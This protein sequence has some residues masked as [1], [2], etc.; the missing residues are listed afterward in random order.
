M[1]IAFLSTFYPYR[2]GIAQFSGALLRA[3][4]HE[5]HEVKAFNFT[6]QYPEF[7]FP[8]KTQLVNDKDT[9][10]PI[11]SY[12]VLDSI[13]PIS[14]LKTSNAIN[15]YSPDVLITSYWM[16]FFAPSMGT[17]ARNIHS[18]TKIVSVLHNVVPHEK[19]FFDKAFSLYFLA[20][21][22]G[23]VALTSKVSKDLH[24]LAPEAKSMLHPHPLYDHFGAKIDTIEARKK[25]NIPQDKKVLLFFGFI[26]DYKGLDILINAFAQLD[27]SYHLLIAGEV[28]GSFDNYQAQI[29]RHPL[30]EHISVY[31]NYIG[32]HEVPTYFS[33]AD[34][35]LL[36][37]KS[38]TQSGITSISYHF[39]LPLI[40][41]N[42]GGLKETIFHNE[43]GLICNQPNAQD[44]ANTITDFFGTDKAEKFK[45]GIQKLKEEWSWKALA[46]KIISFVDTI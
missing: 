22:H 15:T 40:A 21:H 2:G 18:K 45:V 8:G 25:L 37:Y 4:E 19:R 30:K 41:T 27:S 12:R 17:I 3:L 9:A 34:V 16:P 44:L 38:A 28:Y 10:D 33:A 20:P 43:T 1:R 11:E 35:C 46:K 26:R 42:V 31:N 24:E 7:L 5:G 32:D 14:Y 13:N 29:D 6:R 39:D 23:F 36:P